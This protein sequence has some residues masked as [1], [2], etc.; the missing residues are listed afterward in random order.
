MATQSQA[1]FYSSLK[2]YYA[3]YTGVLFPSHLVA[4]LEQ[5]G[6]PTKSGYIFLAA[7]VLLY[8]GI[9]SLSKTA[10]GV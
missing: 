3:F 9:G 6:V 10:D 2:K 5:M 7:T 8:A 1:Q 4:I